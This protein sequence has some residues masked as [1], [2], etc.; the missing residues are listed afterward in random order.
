MKFT[1]SRIVLALAGLAFAGLAA[2]QAYPTRAVKVI[3]PWPPG[4]ATDL[5]G[6]LVADKLS[7][8]L[9]QPFVVENKAGAG[10]Q[11]GTDQVAKAAPDGYTLLVASSGPYSIAPNVQKLPYEPLKDFAP[12][13]MIAGA[14]FALVTHPSFPAANLKE[15]IAL[16][17]ANPD[18]YAFSSSGTGATA[19]LIS[20]YFNSMA[21]LKA[22]HIPY[23]GSAP[24]LTDVMNGQIGYTF[25][26]VASVIGHVRGGRLKAY[27]VSFAR[28][29]SAMPDMVTVAEAAL[30]GFDIGAWIGYAAPAG[31]PR[32]IVARLATEIQKAMNA[33]DLKDR[34]VTLGM[35]AVANTPDD[36]AAMLRREQSRYGEIVKRAGVKQD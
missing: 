34:Y 19:H 32:E 20:E 27:G 6:R 4:Q 14:P 16:V 22:R 29:S 35:D 21:D 31:T 24:A 28:R 25:E 10:G 8:A 30:P 12:I 23:K 26:T 7:Q 2:A 3:V 33:Q 9:G 17:K 11:I 5:A 1:P 15:L 18:K 13:S 36:F